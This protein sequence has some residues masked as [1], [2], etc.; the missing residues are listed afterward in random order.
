MKRM[1]ALLL[2]ALCALLLAIASAAGET[3]LAQALAGSAWSAYAP[4][5]EETEDAL[6]AGV[7]RDA[8][9][10]L[11]FAI[12]EKGEDGGFSLA[13][14]YEKLI[15]QDVVLDELD[16]VSRPADGNVE[17]ASALLSLKKDVQG[18]GGYV[19]FIRGE[20]GWSVQVI[21]A[22]NDETGDLLRLERQEEQRRLSLY[23]I[24]NDKERG[25]SVP[26]D[27][28]DLSPEGCSFE[29]AVQEAKKL[30]EEDESRRFELARETL[31]AAFPYE[32]LIA[33][34]EIVD[35]DLRLDEDGETVLAAAAVIDG[36]NA[37]VTYFDDLYGD[38]PVH[39]VCHNLVPSW[40]EKV[41]IETPCR[42]DR[43]YE[44]GTWNYVRF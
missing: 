13:A 33:Q 42:I 40:A 43:E 26:L 17:C 32:T 24:L 41:V 23:A 29:G 37:R 10:K 20:A 16:V 2:G 6:C 30:L 12:A 1:G 27:A 38:A 31:K 18:Y 36:G 39:T 4:V 44:Y 15:P 22:R 8:Q 34:G 21:S 25:V 14:C 19:D 3:P 35:A 7:A 11:I 9:G 5:L 28:I